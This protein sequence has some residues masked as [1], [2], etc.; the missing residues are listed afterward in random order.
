MVLGSDVV[1]QTVKRHRHAAP[2][3]PVRSAV[4][5]AQLTVSSRHSCKWYYNA[6][7]NRVV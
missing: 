1:C 4:V 7:G 6:A 2:P 5:V 3:Q